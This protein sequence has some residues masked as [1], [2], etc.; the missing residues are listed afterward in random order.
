MPPSPVP[1][2]LSPLA[3]DWWQNV[4]LFSPAAVLLAAV[5]AALINWRIL[6]QRT[7]ADN[8]ALEQ[9]REA[10][11]RALEQKTAADNRAEWWRRAQWALDSSLSDDPGRAKLGL[12]IMTVLAANPPG[13]DE[14]R[15]TTIAWED[16]LQVAEDDVADEG[17]VDTL[18]NPLAT[19]TTPGTVPAAR[20]GGRLFESLEPRGGVD[21]EPKPG[22]NG[23]TTDEKE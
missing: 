17:P 4:A 21:G 10:D 5:L 9:K 3:L 20:P 11:R 18:E 2:P 15:I 8:T 23:S 19:Y 16:P 6:R 13:P 1:S 22:D 12:G 7:K 14:V